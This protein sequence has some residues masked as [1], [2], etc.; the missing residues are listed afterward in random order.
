MTSDSK[1]DSTCSACG[2]ELRPSARFCDGCGSPVSPQKSAEYKQVTV[3][4]ADVVGSMDIAAALGAERLREIMTKLFDR[5]AATVQR[6]RGTVDKFT[7]D[8]IMAVFGAPIALEDHALR[9]CLTALDIQEEMRGLTAEVQAGD[10][11]DVQLRVGLNSGEVIAGDIGSGAWSYTAVGHQVGMAQRMESVAP[12]GGVMLSESTARLVAHATV[13]GEPRKVHIKG[14]DEPVVAWP[15]LSMGTARQ[16][17]GRWVSTLVDRKWELATL[18]AMLDQSTDGRGCVVRV[19]GDAGIGKSRI[20]AETVA[21]AASRGVQVFSTYCESHTSEVPFLVL[22]RLM[23]A[24]FG[25]DGLGENQARALLRDRVPGARETDAA[26]R[27]LLEDALG[28]RDPADELPDVAPD[29]RRRRLTALVNAAALARK[30]PC[31]YVIEDVHWIDATSESLLADFL[32]VVHQT[33]S[34]VLITYR[35]E[36]RGELSHTAGAQTISLAPLDVSDTTALVT[37]LLGIHPSVA[38]LAAQ[39]AERAAGNPFFVEEI[40]RDLCDRGVLEGDRGAHVSAGPVTDVIVPA[41]LQAA[42]AARIDRLDSAAKQTL[43][44]AAVIGFR[45]R[46][47][48]LATLADATTLAGLVQAELVDQVMFTPV[49][50]YAFHQPLIRSVAY[51]SQLKAGRAALHRRVAAAI[52]ERDP[53]LAEENAALI[54]E[55]LELAGDLREAFGWHIRAANWLT[56]L[57]VRAARTAWQRARAV[58]DQ[59]PGDAPGRAAMRIAPRAWLCVS[60]WRVGGSVDDTGFEELHE[61]ATAAGDKASLATGITGQVF[62]LAVYGRYQEACRLVPELLNLGDSVGNPTLTAALLMAAMTARFGTGELTEVMRLSERI[63]ADTEGDPHQGN[64]LIDS[65]LTVALMMRAAASMCKG[66][67]AWKDDVN[68]AVPRCAEFEPGVRAALMLYVYGIGVANRLLRPDAEMLRE[69]AEALRAAEER[70]DEF[71][72]ALARFLRGLILVEG[73]GPQRA[74]G[75]ELLGQSRET[76]LRDRVNQAALQQLKVER[77][78]EQAR[79]G[80]LDAAVTRLRA[81][82][83]EQFRSDGLMFLGA[84]VTALVESLLERGSEA[85]LSEAAGVIDQL[86]VVPTEPDFVLFDVALLRLRALLARARGE[87]AAYRD[88]AQRYRATAASFGFE[89]HLALA[90]VL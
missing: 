81:V 82:V 87:E 22:A 15:L 2:T 64:V 5:C 8:G 55:H 44:A 89:G 43:Y 6:Y 52:A 30:A 17:L 27:V 60:A 88:F 50:E 68:H 37:Q 83:E 66:T 61:L 67:P 74:E 28:I 86:E 11:I 34:L 4:F 56:R 71:A 26:D 7:G 57:D 58:A 59:L 54:A 25:V 19:V 53:A 49:E 20:V 18:T 36:Y 21:I 35:P 10:G 65:P 79:T 33:H 72:L 85:D 39:V 1:A 46:G 47:D 73:E 84:G 13:L 23:R 24:A 63:V 40:V 75:F 16:P 45:F 32:T 78:K 29:A 12:P 77:A 76:A 48:L 3:L 80:D 70:G 41:T 31:V 42:I 51:R 14:S 38:G 9:S 62:A 90:E 69:S